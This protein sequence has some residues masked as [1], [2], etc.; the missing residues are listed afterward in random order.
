MVNRF[1]WVVSTI[2]CCSLLLNSGCQSGSSDEQENPQESNRKS[3]SDAKG[4]VEVDDKKDAGEPP[5]VSGDIPPPIPPAPGPVPIP[6]GDGFGGG[7][8]GAEKPADTGNPDRK[9]H[10]PNGVCGNGEQEVLANNNQCPFDIYGT[11]SDGPDGP[12]YLVGFDLENDG[13]GYTLGQIGPG[14]QRVTDVDFSPDGVLYGVAEDGMNQSI[15]ITI[16]CR[17]GAAAVVGAT[18]IDSNGDNDVI[19]DIAFDALGRLFAYVKFQNNADE[20]GILAPTTGAY[21]S[22]GI[23]GLE[24]N[25]NGIG[26]RPFPFDTLYHTGSSLSNLDRTTGLANTFSGLNFVAPAD[27]NPRI[28]G[29]DADPFTNVMYASINDDN[30][31]NYLGILDTAT[32]DVSF[33]RNPPLEAPDGLDGIAVNRRYE[34]CDPASEEP[35]PAGTGC[36]EDCHLIETICNDRDEEEIIPLLQPEDGI[37]NDQDGLSNCDDP[38]CAMLPCTDTDGCTENDT[39]LPVI[40][41][42]N[43]ICVT[44][45]AYQ[46]IGSAVVCND[47][48]ECTTD[49]CEEETDET[50]DCIETPINETNYGGCTPQGN[51][52][53]D[54]ISVLERNGD[55]SC[56]QEDVIDICLVGRCELGTCAG[57]NKEEVLVANGG[58]NDGDICTADICL[59]NT[60]AEDGSGY[61]EYGAIDDN[62]C[63]IGQ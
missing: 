37:D 60:P 57:Q 15:L 56:S 22:L 43:S 51:C 31:E 6:V 4:T 2:L 30:D 28:N 16:N 48:N 50:Y 58:C 24:D 52:Q 34:E 5:V 23:T 36:S 53:G 14:L 18:G 38:D 63:D 39:C 19:T 40:C 26:A 10:G 55:G 59:D 13:I 17:T 32:G 3:D 44:A 8:Q 62:I 45:E 42:A 61:C 11:T 21:T 49:A 33:L 54:E 27:D 47:G 7:S 1:Y 41:T 20:L 12:S 9:D 46:C 25:G 35:L 29:L